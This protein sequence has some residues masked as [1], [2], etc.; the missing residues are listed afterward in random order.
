MWWRARCGPTLPH[1]RRAFV[2]PQR[3]RSALSV[4]IYSRTRVCAAGLIASSRPSRSEWFLGVTSFHDLLLTLF[5][6][7]IRR[8]L[9]SGSS[10]SLAATSNTS[11]LA[12]RWWEPLPAVFY[13]C[14]QL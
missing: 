7:G 1:Q 4:K 10:W 5:G 12:E 11:A 8:V 2:E 3:L 13:I 9:P 14:C 6:N